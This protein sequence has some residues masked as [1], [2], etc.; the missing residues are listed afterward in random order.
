MWVFR[1]AQCKH[2]AMI[3]TFGAALCVIVVCSV[4]I[5]RFGLSFLYYICMYV[6]WVRAQGAG[7]SM[8]IRCESVLFFCMTVFRFVVSVCTVYVIIQFS[9][10]H[11]YHINEYIVWRQL[12]KS[13]IQQQRKNWTKY[14]TH[15]VNIK[16]APAA[17]TSEQLAFSKPY[18][19]YSH[20]LYIERCT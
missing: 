16:P 18:T 20:I 14:K 3:F 19:M 6:C 11:H 1:L 8:K 7:L 17:T 10:F 13:R 15:G 4:I 12:K 2:T 5:F 9:V